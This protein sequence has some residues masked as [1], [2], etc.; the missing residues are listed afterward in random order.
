MTV[1]RENF[2]SPEL[3]EKMARLTEHIKREISVYVSRRGNVLDVSV[4]EAAQVSLPYMRLRRSTSRLSG[5]RCIHTH[6]GGNPHLSR[7]DLHSLKELSFDAMVAIG[8][9]SGRFKSAYVAML[10]PP[11]ALEEIE[12]FGPLTLKELCDKRLILEI[13]ERDKAIGQESFYDSRKET[14]E[15]AILVGL[16]VDGGGTA[17]LDELEQLAHT[18]GAVVVEK[19]LQS[20]QSPEP[21][22]Y[23]GRGKA[24]ELAL[25]TQ[26]LDASLLIFD[27]ELSGAQIRNLEEI[28]GA[29]V[30]DRT[31]LILDIFAQRAVSREGK[32]QVELAQLKYR[33]PRLMGLGTSLS[34]LGGG[35]GTRG[36]GE[37][38]L[39]TDRRH[40]WRR[41]N[42][43]EKELEKVKDRR[44]SLRE[45]RGKAGFPIVALVG[46][47]NAG[48]STLLNALSG[49]NV[50]VE[51]KLFA[52]LDPVYRGIV[53]KNNQEVLLVDTVGFISKLPHDL[54]DAFR[55]TLEE[56]LYADLLL[57]VVD[58]SAPNLEEQMK[59]VEEVLDS[60][61]AHQPM[62]TVFNKMD[63]VK[64]DRHLPV[65]KPAVYI[66]AAKG[67][68][69]DTLLAMIEENL[70]VQLCE[71]NLLIPYVEAGI[72][73][74]LH[75]KARVLEQDYRSEGIYMRVEI[76][77]A[78]SPKY[79]KYEIG[80]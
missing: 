2:F 43:I 71:M 24:N 19:V 29:R 72:A 5:I 33:L 42:E 58:A 69:L 11:G 49:S 26:S 75:D 36:P 46:Y 22:T 38:K 65:V 62:I 13:R 30:I 25:L 79:K 17:S 41:I 78:F 56:A 51:D 77:K 7:V 34:R 61:G 23:I 63:R 54:V 27:D 40:I 53:L 70:P 64:D 10:N 37:K 20:R 18:A 32:L 59:V 16:N 15:R 76:D 60:L 45:R 8:V 12:I 73:S 68:G 74:A 48:K 3:A 47:T 6:P 57:H 28:T 66:S 80:S 21:G 9:L 35:I 31:T 1:D 55:S 39:E 50:L 14:G 44:D 4:G 67:D 52:T